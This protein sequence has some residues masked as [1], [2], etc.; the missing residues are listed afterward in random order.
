[1]KISDIKIYTPELKD[2]L[3][4]KQITLIKEINQSIKDV[5]SKKY[6]I[7]ESKEK[8]K[9][10]VYSPK[11]INE[12]FSDNIQKSGWNSKRYKFPENKRSFVEVDFVKD[13]LGCEFQFGKYAFAGWDLMKFNIFYQ[14]KMIDAAVFICPS[15]DFHKDMSSGPS[16]FPQVKRMWDRQ[17]HYFPVVLLGIGN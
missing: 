2:S 11:S 13:K 9:G 10:L 8:G 4:D 7:K 16:N 6:L 1:M 15:K 14:E 17:K 3:N 12:S 5:D